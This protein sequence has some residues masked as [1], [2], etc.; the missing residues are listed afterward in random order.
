MRTIATAAAILGVA[1]FA[2]GCA[3]K[4]KEQP[5]PPPVVETPAP[6]PVVSS[7]VLPGSVADFQ[8]S[9]GDIVY[10]DYDQSTLSPEARA[11]LERQAAW[12]KSYPGVKILVEGNCDE[13]GT[14]EY[15]LALGARRAAA[16][17]DYLVALGVTGDRLTTISYGKERPI[18][19]ASSETAWSRNRNAHSAIVSGAV[20]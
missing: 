14:R 6:P 18:D 11:T 4:P 1:T 8:Q 3:S 15:N 9:A 17:K 20:S 2:A 5:A 19:P 7:S 13:R 10:F 16:A 12:L